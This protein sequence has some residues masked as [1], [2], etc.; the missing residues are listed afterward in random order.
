MG[1][2][3]ASRVAVGPRSSYGIEVYGTEGSATWDFEQMN[4]L[5]V[6]GG[7]EAEHQGYT[8]VMAGPGMGDFGSFQPGAGTSMGYDDLKVVEA[9]R[10]LE[11]VLGA[12]HDNSNIAD[13]LAAA[14]VISAAERSAEQRQWQDVAPV[15]GT[16]AARRNSPHTT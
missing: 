1:T 4:E 11:A 14:R 8:R 10:F 5:H 9:R 7:L 12:A 6:S 16:T 15:E 2:L 3:E 13:A